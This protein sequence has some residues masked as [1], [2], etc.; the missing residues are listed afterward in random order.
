VLPTG[1]IVGQAVGAA[2]ALCKKY[3]CTPQTLAQ[4]HAKD[5]QQVLLRQD[6]HI[7][8][9]ANEDPADLARHADVKASSDAKLEFP[10]SSTFHPLRFPTAQLFPVSTSR[11][12]AVELL[13]ESTLAAPVTLKLG[14]RPSK[15]VWDLRSDNR[16]V[17]TATATVPAGHRG[18]VRFSLDA[19]VQP[20]TLYYV[21][22]PATPGISWALYSNEEGQPSRIPVGTSAADLPGQSLWRTLR[23]DRVF[24]MRVLPE[25][26]PYSA[27]NVIR[28]TSRPDR[29]TNLFI[30]DPAKS[31]PVW[32]ELT[33]PRRETLQSVQLT[34]DTNVNRRVRL[35]LF[36]YPEC[37]KSYDIAAEIGGRWHTVA[38]AEDNYQRRRFH[39]FA[40]ISSNQIRINIHGTNGSPS[41]RVYEVRLYGAL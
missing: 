14:L 3:E 7:P 2:A 39:S 30:S 35:P 17:A 41:A 12:D 9:I 25:Q 27:M 18:Y 19:Q 15:Y 6:C 23:Q 4:K 37:V 10:E 40:P 32:I 22:L 16:D 34:F 28:G 20:D 26:R 31:L 8:G 38:Q 11:L 13:L 1:A 24:S 33:L 21:H 5:L 36:R 29:W